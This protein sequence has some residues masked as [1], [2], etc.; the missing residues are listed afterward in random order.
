VW[1]EESAFLNSKNKTF[2]DGFSLILRG[3]SSPQEE[4]EKLIVKFGVPDGI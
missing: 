2:I 4:A 1:S 3:V